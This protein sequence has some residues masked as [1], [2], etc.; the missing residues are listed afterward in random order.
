MLWDVFGT[1]WKVFLR[2]F[3]GHL[4]HWN[5]SSI[6]GVMVQMKFVTDKVPIW[7]LYTTYIYSVFTSIY[8]V[9]HISFWVISSYTSINFLIKWKEKKKNINN[10]LAIW[11]YHNTIPLSK[12]LVLRIFTTHSRDHK[13]SP[14]YCYPFLS[15]LWVSNFLAQFLFPLFLLFL[16]FFIP[17]F[18]LLSI[19]S[20][21]FPSFPSIPYCIFYLTNQITF[22]L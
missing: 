4:D 5:R 2:A 17:L 21:F 15:T 6:S 18:F 3:G 19:I 22:L 8:K 12:F 7:L 9:P 1:V 20:N 10:N 14:F 11:L 13:Y 16:L